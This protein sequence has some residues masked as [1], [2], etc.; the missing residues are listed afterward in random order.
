MEF[1]SV[2]FIEFLCFACVSSFFF[3]GVLS[4]AGVCLHFYCVIRDE[5]I[6]LICDG[7]I[8]DFFFIFTI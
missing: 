3:F 8:V 1:S 4:S 5:E 6:I 2:L 7:V